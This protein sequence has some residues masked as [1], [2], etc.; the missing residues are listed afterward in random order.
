VSRLAQLLE[1]AVDAVRAVPELAGIPIEPVTLP[2]DIWGVIPEG[3]GIGV[4]LVS[5]KWNLADHDLNYYI[6]QPV[7]ALI[8][9]AIKSDSPKDNTEGLV[10]PGQILDLM[11]AVLSMRGMSIG[12]ADETGD[13]YLTGASW[14]TVPSKERAE[15]GAGPLALVVTFQTSTFAL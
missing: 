11:A 8:Q 15:G 12:V 1:N 3:L 7:A 6:D 14:A 5:G 10:G 2:T 4:A 13:V 9:V